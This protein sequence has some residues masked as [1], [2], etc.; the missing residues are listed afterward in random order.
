[1]QNCFSSEENLQDKKELKACLLFYAQW[2]AFLQVATFSQSRSL[3][4]RKICEPPAKGFVWGGHCAHCRHV[5][6]EGANDTIALY[7]IL[8]GSQET[9][10][11]SRFPQASSVKVYEPQ[12]VQGYGYW[13]EEVLLASSPQSKQD[14]FP[15][16]KVML[17]KDFHW[18]VNL[19]GQ[20]PLQKET[21]I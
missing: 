10:D 19:A 15:F 20:N 21:D 14:G 4:I 1:M 6:L 13:E 9:E 12:W 3:G 16:L 5:F 18:E 17:Y 11:L 7:Q 8:K 2:F